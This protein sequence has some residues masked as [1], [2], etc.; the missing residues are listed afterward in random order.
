MI[1]SKFI[2]Q[3]YHEFKENSGEALSIRIFIKS[4]YLKNEPSEN[5]I[6]HRISKII[7]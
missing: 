1:L 5:F 3:M 4:F 2:N 7:V 6:N